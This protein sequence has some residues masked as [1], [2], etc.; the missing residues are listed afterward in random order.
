[1]KHFRKILSLGFLLII[2]QGGVSAQKSTTNNKYVSIEKLVNDKKLTSEIRGLGGYKGEC[3]RFDLTNMTAD[4]LKVLIEAGRRLICLDTPLQDIFIV[5]NKYIT[6]TPNEHEEVNGYGFCCQ[7]SDGSP[8]KDSKFSI[9]FMAP[10]DWV[11]LA[12]V[13]DKNKFPPSAIQSAVWV[14]SN[15]HDISSIHDENLERIKLLRQTVA[16]IKGVEL[17][18]YTQTFE[19]DRSVVF[20]NRPERVTGSFYYELKRAASVTIAVKNKYGELITIL[21][22]E[23]GSERGTH[24]FQLDLIVKDWPKGEY[25]IVVLEDYSILNLKKKFKL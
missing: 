14:L 22:E 20:S 21:L 1:M 4:T 7:S 13:I 6:L 18:W 24:T 16:A 25:E 15:N 19:Y 5:K 17:P 8:Q 2:F 23:D 11:K 10:A 12:K 3:I 9:G